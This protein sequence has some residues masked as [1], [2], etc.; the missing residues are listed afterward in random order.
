MAHNFIII[1]IFTPNNH[2]DHKNICTK[3]SYKY[4]LQMIIMIIEIFAP[5][6]HK[7]IYT[8]RSLW[9]QKYLHQMILKIFTPKDHYDHP[10]ILPSLTPYLPSMPPPK[11]PFPLKI[12]FT[13]IIVIIFVIF[14]IVII[15]FIVITNENTSPLRPFEK[16]LPLKWEL[17]GVFR[18]VSNCQNSNQ[19][20]YGDKFIRGY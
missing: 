5:N 10:T 3:W 20:E 9:S 12:I 11:R 2:Y 15:F 16:C 19:L 1:I 6:D 14:T 18:K 13:I 4:L 17:R 7:N 8:K